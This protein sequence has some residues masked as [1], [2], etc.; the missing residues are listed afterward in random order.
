LPSLPA[1]PLARDVGTRLLGG[2]ES[3]F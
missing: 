3:F 2:H 1:L